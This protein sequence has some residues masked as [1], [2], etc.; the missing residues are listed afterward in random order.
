[1]PRGSIFDRDSRV[2]AMD[3]QVSSLW[4]DPRKV[5]EPERV[6]ASLSALLDLDQ[7]ELLNRLA[8]SD[9]EGSPRKFV[10]VKRWLTDAEVTAVGRLNPD[11]SPGLS[12]AKEWVRFYPEGELG[13]HVVGFVN[14]D[15]QACEGIEL[16][17]D[18]HLRCVPGKYRSRLDAKRRFLESLTLEYVEP[19][20]SENVYLTIDR[21]TQRALE[22][23]LDKAIESSQ[24]PCG[25]GIVMD[26][27]TGAIL[28]MA[29]RPA[30]DPNVYATAPPGYYTNRA[31]VEVF[32]PGR[33]SRS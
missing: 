6:A 20:G 4:A 22:R 7:S 33:R 3:R 15:G 8:P 1:M 32:E 5:D 28:A 19:E 26:P 13:A 9:E 27:K 31:V 18:R 17:W 11:I 16:A 25:M 30:F 21:A 10:W 23:E 14:K 12:L 2:L 24:A 29:C